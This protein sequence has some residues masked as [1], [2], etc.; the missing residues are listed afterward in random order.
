MRAAELLFDNPILM[1]HVRS[2]LRPTQVVPW[3]AVAVV[4]GACV[5]WAGHNV[6]W[7]GDPSAAMILVGMQILTL[8]FGGANQI[9]ASLG[10]A[11]E[12]GILDFHRVSPVP[13]SAATLGFFLGAPIREYV[14]T[15]AT[16]PFALFSAYQVDTS[17][18]GK[19]FSWL[20]QLEVAMLVTTW[21]IHAVTVLVCLT[22]KRPRGSILGTVATVVLLIILSYLGSIGLYFGAQELLERTPRLNLFGLMVPWLPWLLLYEAPL[23]GFLGLAAARKMRA[24][25][26]HAYTKAQALACMTTLTVLMVGGLWQIARLLYEASP[27]EPTPVDAIMLA[28]VYVLA[29][30]AMILTA[31]I[32]PDAGEYVK[33]LRRA[34]HEG[35]RRPSPWSDAG[36][37][38]VALFLLCALVLVGATVVVNVVG[39][40]PYAQLG[41]FQTWGIS[42][43]L[44]ERAQLDDKAWIALRQSMLS[45]PIAVGVLTVA[46]VGLGLQ[47]FSLR[48]RRSGVALMALFL[49]VVWL[50]PVLAGAVIGMSVS[51]PS[52]ERRALTVAALSPLPGLALAS[53]L[54]NPPGAETLRLAALAPAITFAFIFNYLLVVTQRKLDHRLRAQ[55]KAPAAAAPVGAWET[56]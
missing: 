54:G 18:P 3:V 2:R 5:A 27:F 6:P 56:A 44:L 55:A 43:V 29:L 14:L 4:L 42:P 11:R 10:G 7:V 12:S 23:L 48:T 24:E 52:D 17:D 33:G 39:R 35:R 49:F 40:Q 36:S 22:R 20:A 21:V 37:N 9:N 1:K 19:G 28:A 32:T 26:A 15:V 45:R 46:Y 51:S 38:R 25:R 13:P 41:M 53:G 30:V 50:L 34:G 47:Y 16:L 8:T 31:T